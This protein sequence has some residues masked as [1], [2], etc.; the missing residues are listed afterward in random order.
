MKKLKL[1]E[2]LA[3]V[4]HVCCLAMCQNLPADADLSNA[5]NAPP[6]DK[7]TLIR[8]MDTQYTVKVGETLTIPCVIENRKHATVIWQ[9]S[10]NKI[11]ETLTI[12]YFYYRK[13]YRIRVIANTTHEPEQSWNLEIRKV[14]L[15]DEGYYL[16]KVMAEPESLKRVVYLRVEVDLRMHSINHHHQHNQPVSLDRNVVLICNT[17]YAIKESKPSTGGAHNHTH[18]S[19]RVTWFKDNEPILINDQHKQLQQGEGGHATTIPNDSKSGGSSGSS[20]LNSKFIHVVN[21]NSVLNYKIEYSSK[22]VLWSKLIIKSL[23]PANLGV[24]TCSFRNQSVSL[25]VSLE[26]GT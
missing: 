18:G 8:P 13:D 1:Y 17:S 10:K 26:S 21:N 11:P 2:S 6:T 14:K 5:N 4:L 20:E 9:Y 7:P 19:M 12:G 16:C 23:Q 22:P 3:A 24:Y 25:L 15:E